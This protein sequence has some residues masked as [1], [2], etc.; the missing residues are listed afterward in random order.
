MLGR[1]KYAIEPWVGDSR[2]L[3]MDGNR[4]SVRR[5][6]SASHHAPLT[7]WTPH[8]WALD[9][10]GPQ[11]DIFNLSDPCFAARNG[12]DRVKERVILDH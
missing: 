5:L 4:E 2:R 7:H 8:M 1:R 6:E 10:A 12:Q 9:H 11:F 3:D